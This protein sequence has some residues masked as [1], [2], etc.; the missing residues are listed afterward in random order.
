[1]IGFSGAVPTISFSSLEPKFSIAVLIDSAFQISSLC[2]AFELLLKHFGDCFR[3]LADT[4]L[5]LR[6]FGSCE[7]IEFSEQLHRVLRQIVV[8][9]LS[10]QRS[11]AMPP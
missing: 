7:I 1:V 10:A 11:G 3:F 8:N 9:V 4:C 6:A 5:G 2:L